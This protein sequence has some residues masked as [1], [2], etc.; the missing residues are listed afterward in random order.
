MKTTTNT[1]S[2]LAWRQTQRLPRAF[3]LRDGETTLATLRWER[4]LRTL[5]IGE[6]TSGRFAFERKG[7]LHPRV[8]VRTL[9]P[10]PSEAEVRLSWCG[11]GTLE[12]PGGRTCRWSKSGF[13]RSEWAWTDGAGSPL[14]T[15][16][17]VFARLRRRG[18]AQPT[19]IGRDAPDLTLLLLLG[20]YLLVLQLDD[21][22][23]VMA[24]S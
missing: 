1:A 14:V 24:A 21:A 13:W 3:E 4:V 11:G 20:W 5:A 6:S 12:L 17:P 19:S 7:F 8:R 23:V 22:A 2:K 10:R 9:A 18:E 16:R 15:V